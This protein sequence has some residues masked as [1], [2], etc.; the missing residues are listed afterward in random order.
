MLARPLLE[1]RRGLFQE[2]P[3]RFPVVGRLALVQNGFH[4]LQEPGAVAR[5]HAGHTLLQAAQ[6][7]GII[8]GCDAGMYIAGWPAIWPEMFHEGRADDAPDAGFFGAAIDQERVREIACHELAVP[9]WRGI[10]AGA[11]VAVSQ[12]VQRREFRK[13]V[14][15]LVRTQAEA[16]QGFALLNH[17]PDHAVERMSPADREDD[18]V[19]RTR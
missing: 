6:I 7:P 13:T 1:S 14:G 8:A 9:A 10:E 5:V 3:D 15:E 19:N 11:R 12:C 17:V 18:S 4:T 16:L 2:T